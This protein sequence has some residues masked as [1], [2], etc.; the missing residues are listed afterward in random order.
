L[1][2]ASPVVS[3]TGNPLICDGQSVSLV[4]TGSCNGCTVVWSNGLTGSS[5]AVSTPGQYTA[6]FRNNCGDG[7]GAAAITINAANAP[8]TV[9]VITATATTLCNEQSVSLVATGSCN[10]CTVV[11]SNG[12]T[13][14]SIAVS[15]PGQYTAFFRNNCGD[16]PG[17]AAIT[18]NAANAPQTVPVITATATTLCS[19]QS[20]SLVST[21][22]CN[23]CTVVWSNGL[24]GSSIAVS[25]PGQ[26]TAFFRNNC[27]DGPGAA[28]ITINTA[29]APQ[30]VPVITATAT[31]LCSGQSVSLVA[32][33][34][35]S[36]CT[37]VW[38]NGLTGSSIAVSTP[39]QYTAFFRNNCGDGPGAAAITI[40]AA[41]A[42]QTAP[43]ITVIGNTQLC[44][45]QT[46]TLFASG[47]C[48][49]CTLLWSNGQTGSS[50]Q[51]QSA[52]VYFAY[53]LNNCGE[54]P[55][56]AVTSITTDV[57]YVPAVDVNNQCFLAAPNGTNYQW[58]LNNQP[59]TEA[60]GQFWMAQVTG[61][62][63]LSMTNPAG[64]TG[65]SAPL[66]VN[67]CTTADD[68]PQ[69]KL[70]VELFP[71][72]ASD[73]LWLRYSGSGLLTAVRLDLY[74]LDGRWLGCVLQ[75]DQLQEGITQEVKLLPLPA[76]TYY[77][78]FW[79]AQAARWG[80]IVITP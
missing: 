40:N 71:N 11:W 74:G 3:L 54:G 20:V 1:P 10:G 63:T 47:S 9:P 59:I 29:N 12:L 15:T 53:F 13:G 33:G 66:F 76:G 42:P 4:A 27:G 17:A 23:G 36:G 51:V 52:G 48:P 80:S 64:C 73:R 35:C 55:A 75:Q 31:T 60:T 68:E 45:G 39:G 77:Y 2:S 70:L 28:A 61:Y 19:G 37:V 62:Y 5:I 65:T 72:P 78:K 18:I 49:G 7:P 58:Y 67:A 38:S 24:T 56:S 25:T 34:N 57:I 16:G 46:T 21:G 79:S 30:T 43:V 44:A 6:F 50:I 22:S 69:E 8:Q 41:N 26:Y 14:S 32:A